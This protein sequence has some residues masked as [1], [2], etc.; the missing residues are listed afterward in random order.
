MDQVISHVGL[1]DTKQEH[2]IT[3]IMNTLP[4]ELLLYILQLAPTII[5]N[6]GVFIICKRWS[7]LLLLHEACIVPKLQL[8][9]EVGDIKTWKDVRDV[10]NNWVCVI[11]KELGQPSIRSPSDQIRVMYHIRSVYFPEDLKRH[12]KSLY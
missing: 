6:R 7:E 9:S 3:S 5:L 12:V 1:S 11:D 8:L 10:T 4:S 2:S